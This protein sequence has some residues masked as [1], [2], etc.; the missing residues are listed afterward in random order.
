MSLPTFLAAERDT[1]FVNLAKALENSTTR[2]LVIYQL[3]RLIS[4]D[5][6]ELRTNHLVQNDFIWQHQLGAISPRRASATTAYF[7]PRRGTVDAQRHQIDHRG[8][9][10]RHSHL[11]CLGVFGGI[12]GSSQKSRQHQRRSGWSPPYPKQRHRSEIPIELITVQGDTNILREHAHRWSINPLIGAEVPV[13]PFEMQTPTIVAPVHTP[14]SADLGTQ[15]DAEPNLEETKVVCTERKRRT[16]T[17]LHSILTSLTLFFCLGNPLF[18]PLFFLAVLPQWCRSPRSEKAEVTEEPRRVKQRSEPF[19][20][21]EEYIGH[22]LVDD[23]YRMIQACWDAIEE[24]PNHN[25]EQPIVENLGTTLETDDF[26][27]QRLEWEQRSSGWEM[28][29]PGEPEPV[30][31]IPS[32]FSINGSAGNFPRCPIPINQM[33]ME[34]LE[35]RNPT[36]H[37][38]VRRN[39]SAQIRNTTMSEDVRNP[40]GFFTGP[41]FGAPASRAPP[42]T[43]FANLGQENGPRYGR[44]REY[45]HRRRS[46]S[47]SRP[48]QNERQ[49]SVLV[50]STVPTSTQELILNLTRVLQEHLQQ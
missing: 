8:L 10:L 14:G 7:K 29:P 48:R 36:R 4:T 3:E 45:H 25:E 37:R 50:D 44:T 11:P 9:R 20:D 28:M 17:L 42:P 6:I 49:V 22:Q 40:G 13:A 43:S 5:Q 35:S 47:R 23:R 19:V 18:L 31:E 27:N 39:Q 26:E 34:E 38:R 2:A 1:E 15:T 30:P 21:R 16:P 33:Q 32:T 46:P 24:L 12:I 41:G